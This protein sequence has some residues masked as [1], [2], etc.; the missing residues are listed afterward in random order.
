M[1]DEPFLEALL[2]STQRELI[3]AHAALKSAK[4]KALRAA[5]KAMAKHRD[6]ARDRTM[7]CE[8]V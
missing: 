4:V 5:S 8:F 2:G 1:S 6:A 7:R 3:D